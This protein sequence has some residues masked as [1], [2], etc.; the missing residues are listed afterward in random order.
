MCKINPKIDFAFKKLFGSENNKDL[1]ISLI[2]SI[3]DVKATD[4]KGYWSNV[5]M[6]IG[7]DL[8]FDK[9]FIYKTMNIR[10]SSKT[11]LRI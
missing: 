7:E 6:Q 11:D 10:F 2:N 3:L 4:E 1:F 9:W 5:E 8:N